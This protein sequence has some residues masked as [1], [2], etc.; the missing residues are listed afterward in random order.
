VTADLMRG[1]GT[2]TDSRGRRGGTA[3]RMPVP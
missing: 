3:G 1:E 2:S